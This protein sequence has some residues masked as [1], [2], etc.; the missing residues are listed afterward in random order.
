MPQTQ[1]NQIF[2]I[3]SITPYSR[4]TGLPFGT[5]RVIGSVNANF[6]G[7]LV[8]S[9]GGSQKFA[10]AVEEGTI[11]TEIPIALKEYPDFLYEL[12]LGK[13]I[14]ENAAEAL[15]DASTLTNKN[16]TSAVSGTVG[17]ATVD[18][19]AASE[20]DLK[21]GKYV[22]KVIT[23]T[24]VD[25]FILSDIDVLRGTDLVIQDDLLKITASA[26]TI[27]DTGA[28]VTIPNTGLELTSGSGTIAM[29]IGD[30]ATFEVRPINN[31][32]KI[33]TIGAVGEVNQE[34]GMLALTQKRASGEMFELDFLRC[35]MI[36]LPFPMEE[37][38]FSE[39]ESSMRAFYDA[40]ENAV[41][42]MR[43]IFPTTFN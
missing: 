13:A 31:K 17:I 38:S 25:V 26:L 36:G 39:P 5:A 6:A 8:E 35:K 27:A 41:F 28:T 4:V 19:I 22:V 34:F 21:F 30:T 29:T 20:T 24:T 12:S 42:K 14:T 2:G 11:S 1:P 3:H 16:G 7:E 23:A 32:S 9:F 10:W 18:I 33:V 15:G 40:D 43:Q 37:K